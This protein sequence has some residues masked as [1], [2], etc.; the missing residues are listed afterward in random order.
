MKITMV[1]QVEDPVDVDEGHSMGI[2]N[3]A[4]D[5]LYEAVTDAGFAWVEGPTAATDEEES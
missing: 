2:T 4:Y 1:L 5:R 3:D